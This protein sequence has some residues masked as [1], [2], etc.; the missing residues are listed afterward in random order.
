MCGWAPQ[1][2]ACHMNDFYFTT[3][4]KARH[5]ELV[6]RAQQDALAAQLPKRPSLAGRLRDRLAGVNA[7]KINVK[8][9]A[10]ALHRAHA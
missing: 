8:K 3:V 6:A 10:P 4:N 9:A 1:N 7:K 2:D 5:D